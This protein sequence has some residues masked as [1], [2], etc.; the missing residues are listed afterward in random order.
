MDIYQTVVGNNAPDLVITVK[1][2]DVAIDVTGSTVTLIITN[3]KT[4]AVT[5]AAGSCALTTPASGIVTYSPAPNDFP[6]EGRYIGEIKVVYNSGKV[7]RINEK[8]LFLARK[9]TS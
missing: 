9:A 4:G 5:V 7:E 3:E 8:I 6:S 1:R 2:N